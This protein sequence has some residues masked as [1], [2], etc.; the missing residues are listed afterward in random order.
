[1]KRAIRL[2]SAA[3]LL[4]ASVAA[5]AVD[6]TYV[7]ESISSVEH[8]RYGTGSIASGTVLTGVLASGS[9]PTTV[10]VPASTVAAV[11]QCLSYYDVMLKEPGAYA[12]SLTIR[13]ETSTGPGGFPQTSI[14]LITC[15][16]ARNP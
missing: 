13:T 9:A 15:A 1:M 16:L 12:L 11:T 2:A 8:F 14:Q 4:L 7:F 10:T 6:D 3:C 5:H